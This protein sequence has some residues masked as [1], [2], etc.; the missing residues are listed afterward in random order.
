MC[1]GLNGPLTKC[2]STVGMSHVSQR[3]L[4]LTVTMNITFR[5]VEISVFEH[6]LAP[7][8]N[9]CCM[10]DMDVWQRKM[11]IFVFCVILKCDLPPINTSK[12]ISM[13]IKTSLLFS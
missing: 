6:T 3:V 11:V 8:G 5:R 10:A 1:N 12:G 2:F 13:I 9:P 4:G 7:S